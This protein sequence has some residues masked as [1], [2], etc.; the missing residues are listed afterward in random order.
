[1]DMAAVTISV[2][3]M[4]EIQAAQASLATQLWTGLSE[5]IERSSDILQQ[6][7]NIAADTAFNLAE[8]AYF[9][10]DTYQQ[11]VTH[12]LEQRG[13]DPAFIQQQRDALGEQIGGVPERGERFQSGNG[14]PARGG[15]QTS[16][17]CQHCKMGWVDRGRSASC[18]RR[19]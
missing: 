2:G 10:I 7:S 12:M 6:G 3:E 5:A 4:R 1:M 13:F 18:S 9:K 11:A 14:P 19:L 8:E 15:C 17:S 16:E